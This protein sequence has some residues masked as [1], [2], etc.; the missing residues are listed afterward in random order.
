MKLHFDTGINPY[1]KAHEKH[2]DGYQ[3][4]YDRYQKKYGYGVAI[5][6]NLDDSTSKTKFKEEKS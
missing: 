6:Y 2:N 1:L 4:L 5:T 3:N